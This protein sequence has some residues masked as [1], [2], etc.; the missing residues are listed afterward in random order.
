M[1]S[2]RLSFI[3][4]RSRLFEQGAAAFER[5]KAKNRGETIKDRK[6]E[7][8]QT[9]LINKNEVITEPMEENVKAQKRM[10]GT[11]IGRW[12]PHDTRDE[13]VDY[14]QQWSKRT[15][16]PAGKLVRWAGVGL[17]GAQTGRL[18]RAREPH[19]KQ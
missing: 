9:K 13:I 18:F 1:A 5:K 19:G 12:I 2:N 6:I 4:G 7:Q 11:L 17:S 15:E 16:L 3:S 10:W 14:V 8:L